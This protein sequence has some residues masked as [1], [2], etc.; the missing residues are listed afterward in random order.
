MLDSKT[1]WE[2]V[3]ENNRK[4]RECPRHRFA[5]VNA[6]KLGQKFQCQVCRGTMGL[7][8]IGNYIAGFKAAGGKVDDIW[9]GFERKLQP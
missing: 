7:I 5:H 8:E 4:I 1:L 6:V 9:P 2:E 3:K